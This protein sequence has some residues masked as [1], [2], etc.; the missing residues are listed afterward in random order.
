MYKIKINRIVYIISIYISLNLFMFGVVYSKYYL[1]MIASVI[2]FIFATLNRANSIGMIKTGRLSVLSYIYGVFSF[3]V[4]FANSDVLL[5]TLLV[6]VWMVSGIM[7]LG[8][9]LYTIAAL[10]NRGWYVK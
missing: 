6:K 3:G 2:L 10:F 9:C 5:V 4:G 1:L 7:S 8:I